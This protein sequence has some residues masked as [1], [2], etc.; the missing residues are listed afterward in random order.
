MGE[1]GSGRKKDEQLGGRGQEKKL[2]KKKLWGVEPGT[3][4][5]ENHY[6]D[7]QAIVFE[8]LSYGNLISF[9][10]IRGTTS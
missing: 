10:L 8:A 3:F 6:F 5:L 1:K 4:C 9:F 2:K 7:H